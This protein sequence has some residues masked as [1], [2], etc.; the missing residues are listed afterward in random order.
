MIKFEILNTKS[1]TNSNDPSSKFKTH[2]TRDYASTIEQWA[3]RCLE[4]SASN[5]GFV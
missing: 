3:I 1:E 4:F 2:G 5:F